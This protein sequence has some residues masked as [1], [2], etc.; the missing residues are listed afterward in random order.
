M[1]CFRTATIAGNRVEQWGDGYPVLCV[2]AR[3]LLADADYQFL[4]L[5]EHR[6][7]SLE[8]NP[9]HRRTFEFFGYEG[10]GNWVWLGE[11]RGLGS[12]DLDLAQVAGEY[13]LLTE[14]YGASTW[15]TAWLAQTY[16]LAMRPLPA[17][18][19]SSTAET[20]RQAILDE[21]NAYNL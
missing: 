15:N 7:A 12:D 2:A 5:G 18:W 13:R 20:D 21:L 3:D 6:F 11:W 1:G 9:V 16:G 8:G 10:K 19:R 4:S 17:G 14:L